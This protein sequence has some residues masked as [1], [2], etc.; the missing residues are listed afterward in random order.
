MLDNGLGVWTKERS[1]KIGSA[2]QKKSHRFH[3]HFQSASDF[4]GVSGTQ[5]FLEFSLCAEDLCS[6]RV[7]VN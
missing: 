2:D 5:D 1:Y 4:L 3:I 7:A 6:A